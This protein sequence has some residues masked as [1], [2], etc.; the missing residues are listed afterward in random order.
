MGLSFRG[1]FNQKVDSKGRMSIPADFRVVLTDGDPRCPETPLP[2]M[3]VLHGKH[4]NNCLHAYTIEAMEEIE[5]GIKALPRGSEARK[6]ASRMILGKSWDTEVDKDGRIVL[7]Q[8]LRQQIG[9]T[10]EATMAAMGDYFEIW[11]AE[12]YA[13]TEAAEAVAMDAEFDG[14]FDP[15]TLIYPPEKPSKNP[16][17]SE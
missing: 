11:N 4:L 10:G 7:P 3:V 17:E 13:E 8:R 5:A 6:R 9:L 16:P 2:R 12:T 15:L 1:E 14:D